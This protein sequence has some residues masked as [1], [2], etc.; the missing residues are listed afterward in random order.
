MNAIYPGLEAG[1][2]ET[3]PLTS[4]D[5]ICARAPDTLY[6]KYGTRGP[7]EEMR[8]KRPSFEGVFVSEQAN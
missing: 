5:G 8:Q 4:R 6:L 3:K 2:G 1:G 7:R